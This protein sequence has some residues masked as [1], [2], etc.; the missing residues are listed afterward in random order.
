MPT[1]GV[2]LIN[3]GTPAAPTT[4]AVR[5]YLAEFLSDPYVVQIPRFIWKPLL[6]GI[7]LRIRPKKSAALYQ[8]IWL[9]EGSPLSVYS[10]RLTKKLQSEL[11]AKHADKIKVTL[12]MRY[13]QPSIQQALDHLQKH[14]LKQLI[15]LPLFPQYSNS[16]TGS[17]FAEINKLLK[18]WRHIPEVNYIQ[19]Y[20]QEPAYIE[21]ITNSIQTNHS[22]QHLLFSFHGLP[23]RS[24][25]LGDPYFAQCKTTADT[26]T[27][28][29]ALHPA[30]YSLTFQ[31][32][33]G[34]AKW[35]QPYCDQTLI[36][37][38]QEGKK[39]VTAICPGFAVDCLET[40]EEIAIRNREI[41][42]AA[43]GESLEYLPAL[44]DSPA[45][46]KL[47]TTIIEKYTTN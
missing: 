18:S 25:E 21:A 45:Q 6:H 35:L 15:I 34:R 44:N 47:M 23:Q 1:T 10:Q 13:G 19:N 33:F 17:I 31:S 8:K 11:N 39:H 3:L 41:F 38:A 20:Y 28:K 16:T 43:G 9:K 30:D 7:V 4:P 40:L 5:K 2:L 46:L 14:D 37:L 24:V 32:R 42:F 36:K 12:A 27:Q 22:Q 26:I 29:L